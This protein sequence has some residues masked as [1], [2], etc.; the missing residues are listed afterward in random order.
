MIT[1]KDGSNPISLFNDTTPHE[2]AYPT[3][4]PDGSQIAFTMGALE[5]AN[6]IYIVEVPDN[7]RPDS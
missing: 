3:W 4:S 6:A 5:N 1:N 7:L 2:L